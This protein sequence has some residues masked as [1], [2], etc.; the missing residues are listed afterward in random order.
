MTKTNFNL[1]ITRQRNQNKSSIMI[2]HY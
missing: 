2:H 1:T